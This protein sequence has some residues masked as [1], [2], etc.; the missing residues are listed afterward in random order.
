MKQGFSSDILNRWWSSNMSEICWIWH[1]SCLNS[2]CQRL[3][4]LAVT[5]SRSP[6]WWELGWLHLDCGDANDWERLS[7][8]ITCWQNVAKTEYEQNT[9]ELIAL[10]CLDKVRSF[11]PCSSPSRKAPTTILWAWWSKTDTVLVALIP[12]QSHRDHRSLGWQST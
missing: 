8:C 11:P 1:L 12:K 2:L 4:F 9:G 7:Q 5:A 3:Q 6:R 10:L